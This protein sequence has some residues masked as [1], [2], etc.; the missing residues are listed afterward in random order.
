MIDPSKQ[1]PK[2]LTTIKEAHK[3]MDRRRTKTPPELQIHASATLVMAGDP[4]AVDSEKRQDLAG[5]IAQFCVPSE[6]KWVGNLKKSHI[7]NALEELK[8]SLIVRLREH[9]VLAPGE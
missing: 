2:N 1:A 5:E 7:D 3:E 8:Q 9:G 4:F 6:S